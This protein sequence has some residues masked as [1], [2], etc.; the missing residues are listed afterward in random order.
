V[1]A[2][3][4]GHGGRG[5]TASAGIALSSR[6]GVGGHR[7]GSAASTGTGRGVRCIIVAVRGGLRRA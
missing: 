2:A 4:T 1:D 3:S 6:V 5:H 7:A